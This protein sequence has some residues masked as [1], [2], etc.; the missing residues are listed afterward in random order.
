MCSVAL[1]KKL[2]EYEYR[3]VVGGGRTQSLDLF[4]VTCE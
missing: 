3:R 1:S 4:K 2:R